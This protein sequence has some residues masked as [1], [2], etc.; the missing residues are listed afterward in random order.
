MSRWCDAV[1]QLPARTGCWTR[2]AFDTDLAAETTAAT[3]IPRTPTIM[4]RDSKVF[5][6]IG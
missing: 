5:K 1:D 6:F 4:A 3:N 2:T